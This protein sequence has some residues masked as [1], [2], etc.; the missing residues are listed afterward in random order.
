MFRQTIQTWM[1]ERSPRIQI[2]I[3]LS[4]V[5][6][7]LIMVTISIT[8]FVIIHKEHTIKNTWR[9][10]NISLVDTD[11]SVYL[12][13]HY[14]LAEKNA[15][16]EISSTNASVIIGY[17]VYPYSSPKS[18]QTV[19]KWIE[20]IDNLDTVLCYVHYL[21]KDTYIAFIASDVDMPGW[22]VGTAFAFIFFVILIGVMIL[23]YPSKEIYDQ[24]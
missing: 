15:R 13:V 8:G 4:V 3:D 22:K 7:L 24:S 23:I 16:I 12:M 17:P 5:A 14:P 1:D 10:F 2:L 11:P 6:V 20:L 9:I 21:E 18:S 19:I